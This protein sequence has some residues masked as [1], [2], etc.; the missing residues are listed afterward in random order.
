MITRIYIKKLIKDKSTK[1]FIRKD[2]YYSKYYNTLL[3]NFERIYLH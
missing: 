1:S 3:R 2:V